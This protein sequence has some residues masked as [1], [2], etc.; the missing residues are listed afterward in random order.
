MAHAIGLIG[1]AQLQN[2]YPYRGGPEMESR[3]S[4]DDV[5]YFQ[6]RATE[7]RASASSSTNKCARK[8]HESAAVEYER[9]ASG[10]RPVLN[11][12]RA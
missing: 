10:D 1:L 12:V 3:M 11:T 7:E 2:D 6:K 9:R 4:E 8:V 5:R